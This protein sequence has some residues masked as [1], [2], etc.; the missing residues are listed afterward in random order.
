MHVGS[1]LPEILETARLVL[2]PLRLA[3][4]S[5]IQQLFPH[6]EI[7]QFMDVI[8][9]WP[10]PDD[11]ARTHLETTL[12]KM[13]AGQRYDWA[14]TLKSQSE[15][16]LIGVISL[17][18]NDEQNNRGFWL[19][20]E[21]HNKGLMTEA[22]AAVTDFAFYKLDMPLLRLSNAEPNIASQQLK[23]K[24]GAKVISITPDVPYVGGRFSEVNWILTREDWD[25][26]RDQ[27]SRP[28]R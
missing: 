10:Y 27:F 26:H 16:Q 24:A 23:V 2:R 19:A 7:L 9:P 15:D 25:M 1:E 18:P 4:A 13:A 17:L 11:G 14:I 21:Y 20:K 3:D 5:R 8:I 12:P 28:S 6:L 22:V